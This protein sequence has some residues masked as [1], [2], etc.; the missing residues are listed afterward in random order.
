VIDAQPVT[1]T[2]HIPQEREVCR[3]EE[4]YYPVA[5]RRSATP[6]I[7]GA[8]LGGV[9]GNQFGGG[10]GQDIMTVAGAALGTSVAADQQARRNPAGYTVGSERR[11]AV[12]TDWRTEQRVVAWDVTWV[13]LGEQYTTRMAEH[14]GDRVKVRVQVDAIN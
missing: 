9:I 14:P 5:P 1:E 12:E 8:I 6:L 11:C 3:D 4:V 13:Y 2:I 7:V 10:R